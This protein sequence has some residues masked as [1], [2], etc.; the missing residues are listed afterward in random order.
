MLETNI[1]YR[2]Q[3][4]AESCLIEATSGC[5]YGAC[6][7]CPASRASRQ[8]TIF[9]IEHIKKQILEIKNKSTD[10]N[11]QNF[12]LVGSNVFGLDTSY[13]CK[14]MELIINEFPSVKRI[15]MNA[16]VKDVLSKSKNDLF[17]LKEHQLGECY[18]GIE[19]GSDKILREI[20]KG[21]NT[22]E[23]LYATQ[24]LDNCG[25]SYS[26]SAILGLGGKYQWEENALCTADFFNK[27]HPRAIRMTS[28]VPW[29]GTVLYDEV[30]SGKFI[31][32]SPLECMIEERLLIEH[33]NLQDCIFLA[34]HNSNV[35]PV[36]GILPQHKDVILHTLDYAISNYNNLPK[37]VFNLQHM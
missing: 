8:Y 10:S 11:E 35:I 1:F 12:F 2:P 33:I 34:T 7:F 26:Y 6:T 37:T 28:L 36:A 13:L 23:M 5:S 19:S 15:S 31:L 3:L 30:A 21:Q 29:E 27:T 18:I 9:S 4:E 14:I 16:R 20:R 25:I 17:L 32:S 24:V 22:S